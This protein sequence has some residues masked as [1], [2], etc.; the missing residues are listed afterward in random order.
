[1]VIRNVQKSCSNAVVVTAHEII[2]G[3][4][5][6]V[7]SGNRD[8]F[9]TRDINALAVIVLVVFSRCYGKTGNCAFSVVINTVHVR[10]EHRLSV[11]VHGDCGICPPEEGLRHRSPV[12]KLSSDLNICF[13]RIKSD[14]SDHLCAVHPVHITEKERLA[15]VFVFTDLN[16]YRHIGRGP[17]VLGPVEL[18]ASGYP[19]TCESHKRGL[20]HLIVINKIVAVGLV[21]SALYP[22]SKLRQDHHF[23]IAVLKKDRVPFL[24]FFLSADSLCCGIGIYLSRT[25]LIDSLFQKHRVSVGCS[26]LIGRDRDFFFPDLYFVH[27]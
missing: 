11:V 25:S 9:V 14:R 13:V 7:G 21:V 5:R 2:V 22:A 19:G 6:H 26:R 18:Y 8:V 12:V 4:L 3:V 1:M 16:V 23:D 10:R 15:A 20:Y 27:I 17:V 24:V